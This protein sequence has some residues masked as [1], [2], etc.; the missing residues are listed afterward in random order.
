METYV[1]L[2]DSITAGYD[3][4]RGLPQEQ[5]YPSMLA[6]KM[7]W[8]LTN[9]AI[10][11]TKYRAGSTQF[12][13]VVNRTDF[14]KFDHCSV[15][16]GVNNYDAPIKSESL[17]SLQKIITQG[18]SKIRRDNPNI[19]VALMTPTPT[20]RYTE[21]LD[22]KNR[23]NWSQ[24]QLCDL[25]VTVGNNFGVTVIDWRKQA[26]YLIT[27]ENRFDTLGDALVHPN[28]NTQKQMTK[29][30]LRSWKQWQI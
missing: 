1:S 28:Y 26:P 20:F 10:S 4:I 17:D 6:S 7:S 25:V 19:D 11:G 9:R 29:I 30:I 24:N 13:G 2:G 16:Y 5:V 18:L 21:S 12:L 8:N 15:M 23:L 22:T 27:N 3:G 14:S